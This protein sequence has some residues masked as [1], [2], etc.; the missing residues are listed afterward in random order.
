M[1]SYDKYGRECQHLNGGQ[2]RI[3]YKRK[4]LKIK[5][6]IKIT[7]SLRLT[8]NYQWVGVD[9]AAQ[10][11]LLNPLPPPSPQPPPSTPPAPP[12]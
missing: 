5:A 8:Q 11:Y 4:K 10:I 2:Q 1:M 6:K 7:L 9:H 12:Q 3:T